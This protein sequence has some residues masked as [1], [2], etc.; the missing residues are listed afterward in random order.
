[1]GYD[2]AASERFRQKLKTER[3]DRGWSQTKLAQEMTRV[4]GVRAH[5]NTIAKIETGERSVSI[6][7]AAA[8]AEVFGISTDRLL[9]RRARPQSDRD[10]ALRRLQQSIE[11]T[12]R[13]VRV[14][15]RDVGER[16]SELLDVDSA[17]AFAALVEQVGNAT[18]NLSGSA[19]QLA[20][21]GGLTAET[22]THR[23]TW[24][25]VRVTDEEGEHDA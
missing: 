17:G 24:K 19:E 18:D 14:G 16:I 23:A 21:C 10:F 13:A 12:H 22:R 8:I 15:L 5:Q 25:A 7:E 11:D 6:A 20:Q 1:M 4:R 3:T 2:D 9:G